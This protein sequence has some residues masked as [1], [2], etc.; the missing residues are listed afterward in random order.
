MC[1]AETGGADGRKI[2]VADLTAGFRHRCGKAH[3][4]VGVGIARRPTAIGQHLGLVQFGQDCAHLAVRG[5]AV[6]TAVDFGHG[7]GDPLAGLGLDG[8]FAQG[9]IKAEI[10]FKRQPPRA[11][12]ETRQARKS[13]HDA[14]LHIFGSGAHG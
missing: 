5:Q 14:D 4:R 11:V 13:R 8:A 3:R 9:T 10:A 1:V 12:S 7:K 6:V 2:A